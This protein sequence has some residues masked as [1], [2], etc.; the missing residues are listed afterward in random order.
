MKTIS[1]VGAPRPVTPSAVLADRLA[2]IRDRVESMDDV[3]AELVAE[4]RNAAELA[5]GVDPYTIRLTTPESPALR[6]L[7]ERTAQEDWGSRAGSGPATG[8]EQEMLSGHVE[9]ATLRMLVRATGASRV[10]EIGMF[11]GYSA[12]AMAEAL[13][14][15]GRLVA[16]EVDEYVARFAQECFAASPAGERISVRVGPALATLADLAAEGVAFDLVFVDADKAGYADYFAT[17]LD[18]DLL[19][20]GRAAVCRQHPDAGGSVALR[21]LDAQR[22]R[23]RRLQRAGRG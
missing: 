11:T 12:L 3:D 16:C 23:D 4:V 9:G 17:L 18:T 7:A 10:L 20:A 5:A 1:P 14:P 22:D 2:W 6:A 21:R 8:L 19:A 13:P 15:D